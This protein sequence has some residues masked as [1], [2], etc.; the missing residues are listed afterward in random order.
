[1]DC[2]INVGM[3]K[4]EPANPEGVPC[5]CLEKYEAFSSRVSEQC[6]TLYMAHFRCDEHW[7]QKGQSVSAGRWWRKKNG[8]ILGAPAAPDLVRGSQCVYAVMNKRSQSLMISNSL[9]VAARTLHGKVR[10]LRNRYNKM[11][12][13][14]GR[15]CSK[16]GHQRSNGGHCSY[17]HT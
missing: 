12:Y 17:N 15:D 5:I 7:R 13:C 11:G 14:V 16:P 8:P 6:F 9:T 2:R 3:Q 10:W 4:Q 1:M